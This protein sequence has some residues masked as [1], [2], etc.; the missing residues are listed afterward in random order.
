MQN[1]QKISSPVGLF[2]ESRRLLERGGQVWKLVS[3]EHKR[4]LL[5][6]MFVVMIISGGNT[7]LALLLGRLVDGIHAGL[8]AQ[9]TTQ[10]LYFGAGKV[11]LL[12]A[13]I[14]LFRELLGV[15]RRKL[16]TD[17]CGGISCEM[18]TK[19]VDHLMKIDLNL[20]SQERIG[21]LHGKIFRSVD[22]FVR[23]VRLMFLDCLPALATGVFALFATMFKQPIFGVVMAGVIPLSVYLT[24]RQLASQKGVRLDLMRDCEEIDGIVVE[25]LSGAEYIRVAHTLPQEMRRLSQAAETRRRREVKHH[26]AMSLFGCAKALNEGFFHI[27]VLGLATYYAVHREI[28]FGDILTFSVLFTS[29]MAPLN[30][31]HR[32][33][34][35]GHE[36][37]LCLADLVEMLNT[38]VDRAF[39]TPVGAA[40]RLNCGDAAITVEDL[41][42]DYVTAGGVKRSGLNGI[43]LQ[44][45]HG[46]T[47]GVAGRSG[48]GKSTWIKALLRTLHPKNGRI[49]VGGVPL[50]DIGRPEIAQLVGY[51]G[52][53]PFIFSGTIRDNISYGNGELDHEAICRAVEMANLK[54][55]IESMPLGYETP[56]TERGQNLSGGQRQRIAIARILL[57]QAPLLVLDE[58]TSAL[59]NI[60]E[61]NV[62][63]ALGVLNQDRTTIMVAHRL[64]TLRDCDRILVFEN[65]R[66]VEVGDYETLVDRG[67]LFAELVASGEQSAVEDLLVEQPMC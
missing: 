53:N 46:E 20:L 59:D 47:I 28:S 33:I 22:G 43:C 17:S 2:V 26:F 6:A 50:D 4:A 18:Q 38:P 23:F 58:A 9:S 12:I 10:S 66:I 62:Q 5:A 55:D 34:D 30:E 19:T 48:S 40:A 13:A 32:V 36:A 15:L 44:I 21:T 67:G 51:V 27:A 25:Q 31:I 56:V 57:K 7:G 64:T 61:R 24:M 39:N 1:A 3:G 14:Y 8:E 11:L 41:A 65:G 63:R 52:Q 29:V 42:F 54:D 35:E 16:V 60:S 45:N 37:S 49:L